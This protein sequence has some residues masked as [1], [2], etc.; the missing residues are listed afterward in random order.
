MRVGLGSRRAQR[1]HLAPQPRR[2]ER[3]LHHQRELVEVERLVGVVI[4]PLLH[5]LDGRLDRRERRQQDHRHVGVRRLHRRAAPGRPSRVGQLDSRAG[6]GRCRD[7]SARAPPARS[8]P[9]RPCGRPATGARRASSGSAARR[10][11]RESWRASADYRRIAGRCRCAVRR[12]RLRPAP[13][14]RWRAIRTACRTVLNAPA[15]IASVEDLRRA[16]RGHH[17]DRGTP[18]ASRRTPRRSV[19]SSQSGRRQ[20]EQRDGKRSRRCRRAQ[21]L[22]RGA[23]LDDRVARGLE[24]SATAQR[25]SGSSSTTRMRLHGRIFSC[26]AG[27]FPAA[28]PLARADH[29]AASIP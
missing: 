9:R 14:R 28:A 17:D 21:R 12:P 15:R 19:R 6:R 26:P 13:G 27:L 8:R 3:L 1:L 29:R 24:T 16:V 18:G 2:L 5:R 4:R 20:I 7:R 10:R 25:I 23:G 22:P 11:R